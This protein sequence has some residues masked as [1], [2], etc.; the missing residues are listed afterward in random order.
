MVGRGSHHQAGS[1]VASMINIEEF[2]RALRDGVAP[3]QDNPHEELSKLLKTHA[4]LGGKEF[5]G[6]EGV[7]GV[8]TWIRTQERIFTDM[9][10]NDQRKRQIASRKLK[11]VAL[12]WWEVIIAGRQENE[13][14]W[15]EFKTMLEARFVPASARASLLEEFIR[16]RQGSM[17]H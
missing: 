1:S 4:N 12:G 10:V 2:V 7:M 17:S 15:D 14:T 9:Q 13:I 8:Q 6:T 11:G 3:R 16:L 5:E